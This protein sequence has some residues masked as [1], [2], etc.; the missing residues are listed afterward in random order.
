MNKFEF[1]LILLIGIMLLNHYYLYTS[2]NTFVDEYYSKKFQFRK[3][4]K[5]NKVEKL[6]RL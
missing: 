4:F 5:T 1:V 3:A 2:T 6:I